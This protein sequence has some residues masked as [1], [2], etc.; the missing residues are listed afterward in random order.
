MNVIIGFDG[1]PVMTRPTPPPSHVDCMSVHAA[2]PALSPRLTSVWSVCRTVSS[3]RWSCCGRSLTSISWSAAVVPSAAG[4]AAST[5]PWGTNRSTTWPVQLST[6]S[7][8]L[9]ELRANYHLTAVRRRGLRGSCTSPS[10]RLWRAFSW[11]I[12]CSLFTAQIRVNRDRCKTSLPA[13]DIEKHKVDIFIY[14]CWEQ[15][16]EH[17]TCLV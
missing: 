2:D 14:I 16:Q 15:F 17:K 10:L 5:S 8:F 4:T 9:L 1:A 11:I 6:T 13:E 3:A 12:A 7:Q